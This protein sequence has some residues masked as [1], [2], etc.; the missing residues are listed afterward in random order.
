MIRA[1]REER[2]LYRRNV[3]PW[4]ADFCV[5]PT[6]SNPVQGEGRSWR[7]GRSLGSHAKPY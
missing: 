4:T 5:M 1:K 2:Y 7:N 3:P 6:V